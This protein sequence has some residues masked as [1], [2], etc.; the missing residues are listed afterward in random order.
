[1]RNVSPFQACRGYGHRV[2]I[3][4]CNAVTTLPTPVGPQD[5]VHVGPSSSARSVAVAGLDLANGQS[6]G[7]F[8]RAYDAGS[9]R[10]LWLL[11]AYRT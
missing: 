9:G 1:M 2:V 4:P 10:E 6:S 7:W 5:V 8:V 3:T 11:R